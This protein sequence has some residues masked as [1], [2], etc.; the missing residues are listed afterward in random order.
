MAVPAQD[1]QTLQQFID[2]SLGQGS[3]A[4]YNDGQFLGECVSLVNQYCWR[5]LDVPADSWGHAKDWATN[6]NVAK[7]FDKVNDLRP[8]DILVYGS[9]FGGGYGHIEIYLGSGLVLGQNRDNKRRV[10]RYRTLPGYTT[11]L[12]KKGEPM[13]QDTNQEYGRWVKLGNQIRGR[14]LSRDEFRKAAVGKEWL[15]AMEILSD[16]AEA[17]T[18]THWQNVG[19][20]AVRDKWDKQIFDLQAENK[21]LK[22][23]L[24]AGGID[25]ATKDKITETNTNVSWIKS[26]L[27]R[28]FK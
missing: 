26:L 18:A 13:I 2:W 27:S 14:D 22:D 16:N 8:G 19:R 12:R 28:V 9:N 20:T 15:T 7:Y 23:Q 21:K 6:A 1:R 4:K 5:V 24:A 17:D 10:G 25:Q 11:I 3:V